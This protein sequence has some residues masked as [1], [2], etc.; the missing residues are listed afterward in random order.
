MTPV[1]GI[2]ASSTQQGRTTA[3][4]S[5]DVLSSIT[6]A[7]S[8]NAITFAGIP[9]D[10]KHLQIR[11]SVRCTGGAGTT[12]LWWRMNDLAS[13]SNYVSHGLG[14]DGA[15]AYSY[16]LVSSYSMGLIGSTASS[17]S[18]ANAYSAIIF[19]VLDYAASNKNKTVKS[20]RGED[21]NGSGDIR[22][23]SSAFISTSPVTSISIGFFDN[24]G[25]FFNTLS[26][27]TLYG[28]K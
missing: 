28:I 2:I 4:G 18:T 10:Y 14:G 15:S 11:A 9:S 6:P 25:S 3:V 20:L 19:D 24:A 17:A 27:L 26:N 5:Y 12:L 7:S 23:A 1:L 13:T 21:F 22:L 16:N 8:V